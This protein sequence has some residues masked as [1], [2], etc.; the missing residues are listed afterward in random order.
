LCLPVRIVMGYSGVSN[1]FDRSS[2]PARYFQVYLTFHERLDFLKGLRCGRDQVNLLELHLALKAPLPRLLF[3]GC[4]PGSCDVRTVK[5]LILDVKEVKD[6][7]RAHAV[8][9]VLHGHG[10]SEET[11]SDAFLFGTRR[12]M[13]DVPC[14]AVE[15]R[16]R[17]IC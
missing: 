12:A 5:E 15:E 13:K 7:P 1:K 8:V 11:P 14:G 4:H 6:A 9:L 17:R 16:A 10:G 3:I 2:R